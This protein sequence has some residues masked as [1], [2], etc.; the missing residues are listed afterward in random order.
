[1]QSHVIRLPL[2]NVLGLVDLLTFTMPQFSEDNKEIFEKLKLSA[3]QLD[4]VIRQVA[5]K[6]PKL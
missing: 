3:N 6:Q 2:A 5:E 1:M 4:E